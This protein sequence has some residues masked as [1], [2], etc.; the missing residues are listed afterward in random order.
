MCTKVELEKSPRLYIIV[1]SF[2]P[3]ALVT[4]H[5]CMGGDDLSTCKNSI[6]IRQS[7]CEGYMQKDLLVRRGILSHIDRGGGNCPT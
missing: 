4:A 3:P 6:C 7:R 5:K 1:I 2:I